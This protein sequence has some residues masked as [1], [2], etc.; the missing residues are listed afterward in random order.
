MLAFNFAFV[1]K[2]LWED[3]ERKLLVQWIGKEIKKDCDNPGILICC[4]SDFVLKII[5][6][7]VSANLD[8]K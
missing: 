8:M 6:S 3:L 2:Q 7:N 4:M 1:Y 5:F